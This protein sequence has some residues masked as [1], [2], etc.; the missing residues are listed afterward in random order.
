MLI[1]YFTYVI[2]VINLLSPYCETEKNSINPGGTSVH[3]KQHFVLLFYRTQYLR[4]HLQCYA[5]SVEGIY[6]PLTG[7]I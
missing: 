6:S 4:Q 1:T 2:R 5:A 3:G 7:F